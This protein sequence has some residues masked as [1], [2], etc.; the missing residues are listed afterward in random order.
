M[1]DL[2]LIE[3]KAEKN[4]SIAGLELKR[5]IIYVMC[6]FIIRGWTINIHSEQNAL[7]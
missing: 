6:E 3:V 4:G 2:T 1:L 5:L 7:M